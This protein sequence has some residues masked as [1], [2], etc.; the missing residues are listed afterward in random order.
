MTTSN[1]NHAGIPVL[2]FASY[3]DAFGARTVQVPVSAPCRASVLVDAM[4]VMPGG[5]RLP[6]VPLLAVNQTWIDLD[7][8]VQP[9]DEV[10]LIPPV[11]GG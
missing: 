8:V 1:S 5:A 2:L 6:E 7:A 11:A 9:G 10:A 4:R 3:A